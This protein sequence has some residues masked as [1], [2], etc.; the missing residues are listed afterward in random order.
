M[1]STSK[2]TA[3]EAGGPLD[4]WL[5][6]LE[7]TLLA[8]LLFGMLALGCAQIILRNFFDAAIAWADPAVR[9]GV[10]WLGLLGAVAA[11]RKAKH[12]RIDVLHR[13]ASERIQAVLDSV[14]ALATAGVAA[15]IA[16]HGVRM[17]LDEYTYP[18][19]TASVL[20]SWILQTVIPGA[21]ALI[22]VAYLVHLVLAVIRAVRG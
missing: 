12:I 17:V 10:L 13:F 5:G 7:G 9:V 1:S 4:R 6:V 2:Q 19:T 16:W 14:A 20:P 3:Q 8:L 11:A 21:F 22:A 18:T 15:V